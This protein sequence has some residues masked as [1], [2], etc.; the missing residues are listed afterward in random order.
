MRKKLA[1]TRAIVWGN[2]VR[3]SQRLV[4]DLDVANA[5]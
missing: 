1:V 2:A 4:S 5:V 3:V